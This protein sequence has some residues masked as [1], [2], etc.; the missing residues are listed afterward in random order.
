MKS[1]EKLERNYISEWVK[2]NRLENLKEILSEVRIDEVKLYKL[3]NTNF[4]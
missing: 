2:T 1:I 3:T 4:S